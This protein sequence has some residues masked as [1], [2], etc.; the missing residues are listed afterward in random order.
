M[1]T[2]KLISYASFGTGIINDAVALT[3]VNQDKNEFAIIIHYVT[4][5]THT[6][7][8]AC[9]IGDLKIAGLCA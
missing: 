8:F 3:I 7:F 9:K 1:Q 5:V 2:Q 4:Q 6:L